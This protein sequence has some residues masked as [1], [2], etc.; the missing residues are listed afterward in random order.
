MDPHPVLADAL[1]GR[2]P[3]REDRDVAARCS[4]AAATTT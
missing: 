3:P 1:E 4:R 2:L